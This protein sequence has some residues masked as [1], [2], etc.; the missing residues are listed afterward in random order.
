[1]K[2]IEICGGIASGK[3]TLATLLAESISATLVHEQFRENP[4]WSSFYAEPTI[5]VEE[6]NFCFLVQHIGGIKAAR[7][8]EFTICDYAVSQDLAYASLVPR[9]EHASLMLA[10]HDHLYSVLPPPTLI[11][12]LKCEPH[13]LLQR[14]RARARTEETNITIDYLATL[15][16][17]IETLLNEHANRAPVHCI[18]SDLVNFAT[19]T[20]T[21]VSVKRDILASVSR[22]L[23]P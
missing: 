2:R 5:W 16:R 1:M 12:Y 4:F 6:K 10:L 20:A 11:V 17:A 8:A 3:T 9:R 7:D 19:D 15:N 22:A 13:V 23:I 14:I 21:A 18:S